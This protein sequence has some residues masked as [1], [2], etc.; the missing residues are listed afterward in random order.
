[1]IEFI[2]TQTLKN[3]IPKS[4]ALERKHFG[5]Q[6]FDEAQ[7]MRWWSQGRFFYAG[8]YDTMREEMISSVAILL[9]GEPSYRMLIEGGHESQ[10]I[11]Y[12][13]ESMQVGYLY[14]GGMIIGNKLH[15]PYLYHKITRDIV[16]CARRE[17]ISIRYCFSIPTGAA[18]ERLLR[19]YGFE[20][21]GRY[22]GKFPIM[23][24][25]TVGPYMWQAF[26]KGAEA[27]EGER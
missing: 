17:D 8:A 14:L 1:M 25:P 3:F 13:L 12:P 27:G 5:D 6:A 4:V 2:T 10:M 22:R 15:T 21:Q 26:L 9:I 19:R 16:A 11:P 24:A 7:V 20:E 23:T 18:V